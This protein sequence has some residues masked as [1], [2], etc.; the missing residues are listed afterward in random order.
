MHLEGSTINNEDSNEADAG[1]LSDIIEL[2]KPKHK[3]YVSKMAY[4][5]EQIQLK[6]F[7]QHLSAPVLGVDL[8]EELLQA[9]KGI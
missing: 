8:A 5:Y 9:I 6:E 3:D 7:C 1:D 2:I 4:R